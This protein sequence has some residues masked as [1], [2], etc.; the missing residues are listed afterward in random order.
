MSLVKAI[1]KMA[2]DAGASLNLGFKGQI[3]DHFHFPY[4]LFS[5]VCFLSVVC[6]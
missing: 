5:H 1:P 6:V 2:R 3:L 4:Y